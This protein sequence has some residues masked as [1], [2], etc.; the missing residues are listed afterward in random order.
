[1]KL[2]TVTLRGY[3]SITKLEAFELRNL[4]VLIGANGAGKSNFI[5]NRSFHRLLLSGVDVEFSVGDEKKTDLVHLIDFA[6]PQHNEFLVI[7]QFTVTGT[8][9]PRRPDLVAFINGLSPVPCR[10]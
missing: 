4:N 2:K 5:G 10:A 6:N 9:Q 3:K 1:M 8:K 7:N